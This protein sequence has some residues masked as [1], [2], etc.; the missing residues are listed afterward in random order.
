MRKQKT[1]FA[2]IIALGMFVAAQAALAGTAH[3][4]WNANT[5]PDLDGYKVYYDTTSH[6]SGTCP[7]DYGAADYDVTDQTA[8]GH[9]FDTLTPGQT[10]YFRLTAYDNATTPNESGC[11]ATEVSKVIT[12]RGDIDSTP[13]HDVDVS[14]LSILAGVYG[15]TITHRADINRDG[16]IGVSDLSI[17]A[18]EFGSSF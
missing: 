11:N 16:T 3:L 2:A 5:E 1:I 4:T 15:Q 9:W 10:Y 17:L 7:G 6:S 18:G 13:D 8:T 12:Y 14:D